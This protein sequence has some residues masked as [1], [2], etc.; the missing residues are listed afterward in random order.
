MLVAWYYLL[1]TYLLIIR[2][3]KMHYTNVH[4]TADHMIPYLDRFVFDLMIENF[5]M[6][7]ILEKKLYSNHPKMEE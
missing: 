2:N 6:Y 4:S 5:A 1:S 3:T 7:I